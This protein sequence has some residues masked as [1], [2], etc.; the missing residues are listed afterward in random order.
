MV[1][2]V[3]ADKFPTAHG[4]SRLILWACLLRRLMRFDGVG[5]IDIL[6]PVVILLSILVNEVAAVV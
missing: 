1:I 2:L 6:F 4:E 3:F 5:I